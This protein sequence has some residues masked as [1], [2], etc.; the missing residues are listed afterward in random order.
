MSNGMNVRYLVSVWA[1]GEKDISSLD[2]IENVDGLILVQP[3]GSGSGGFKPAL[4][5][6]PAFGVSINFAAPFPML[7][8]TIL[9]DLNGL[10]NHVCRKGCPLSF[11][12]SADSWAATENLCKGESRRQNQDRQ[13]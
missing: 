5:A 12:V 2:G 8:V 6:H 1:H 11:L 13:E 4:V 9:Q 10:R 7:A 3:L